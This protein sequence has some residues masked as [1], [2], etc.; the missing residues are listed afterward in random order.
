MVLSQF[1]QDNYHKGHLMTPI[2]HILSICLASIADLTNY[3]FGQIRR[4]VVGVEHSII[5]WN[6]RMLH[7]RW[8]FI[9]AKCAERYAF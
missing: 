8:Y 4:T 2:I 7:S 9:C 5:V 3:P 6:N 1:G